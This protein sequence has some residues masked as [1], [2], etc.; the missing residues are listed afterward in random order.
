[1]VSAVYP[2]RHMLRP[3][4]VEIFLTNR[5]GLMFTFDSSAVVAKVC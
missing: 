2:R 4:A 1:M 5:T 3:T